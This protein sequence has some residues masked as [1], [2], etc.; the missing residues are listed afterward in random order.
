MKMEK[1]IFAGIYFQIFSEKTFSGFPGIF[2]SKFSRKIMKSPGA[3]NVVNSNKIQCNF[4]ENHGILDFL[5][6]YMDPEF[7]SEFLENM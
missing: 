3:R 2:F 4:R 5:L 7:P 1:D 6:F